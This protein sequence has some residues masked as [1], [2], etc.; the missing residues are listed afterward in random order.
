V[1]G[2]TGTNGK[3]TTTAL[4]H[5]ILKTAGVPTEIGGNIGLPILARIRCRRA[6]STC[7]SCRATRST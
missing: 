2:I 1:V 4:I 7:S 5:H 3:S 6:G